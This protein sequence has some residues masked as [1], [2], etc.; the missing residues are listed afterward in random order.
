M[1][2]LVIHRKFLRRLA[3]KTCF[4][5]RTS[6]M[7]HN[8]DGKYREL[9]LNSTHLFIVAVVVMSLTFLRS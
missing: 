9:E 7:D 1:N 8:D 6:L 4:A 3:R 5:V 2:S